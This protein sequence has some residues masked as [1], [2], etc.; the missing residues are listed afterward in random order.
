MSEENEAA[1]NEAI[2]TSEEVQK[3]NLQQQLLVAQA[4][5]QLNLLHQQYHRPP[6]A[7]TLFYPTVPGALSVGKFPNP[8]SVVRFLAGNN[9]EAQK[10]LSRKA[11]VIIRMRGLPYDASSKQVV[12]NVLLVSR[13]LLSYFVSKNACLSFSFTYKMKVNLVYLYI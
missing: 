8:A 10:F 2:L 1:S 11:Q 9:L 12:S 3:V 6:T 13:Y 7:T 4:E 5:Q